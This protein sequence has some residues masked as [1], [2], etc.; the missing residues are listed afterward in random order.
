MNAPEQINVS[1]VNGWRDCFTTIVYDDH[2]GEIV[3][4]NTE[5]T[6]TDIHESA[7]AE[8]DKEIVAL[9]QRIKELEAVLK[10]ISK[11]FQQFDFEIE[12]NDFRD[13][14]PDSPISE[15]IRFC[16]EITIGDL[17][18]LQHAIARGEPNAK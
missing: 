16:Q 1:R 12:V 4:T 18:E 15:Y 7:L 10:S 14:P 5:Y 2:F 13:L 6:R 9:K 17:L 3:F 11:A 8:K